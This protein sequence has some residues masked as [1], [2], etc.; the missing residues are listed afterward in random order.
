M[1]L[2]YKNTI[3]VGT[4]FL[5]ISLFWQVYDNIVS[6]ILDKVFLFNNADRGI[7]MALDNIV[8]LF[9]L[10]L[11]GTLSDKTHC[12]FGKRTPFIVVGTI[13]ASLTF[14]F[15]G[16]FAD[17]V[18]LVGFMIAL[19][20]VLFFMSI[21]RS[22]AVALMPD[23][24]I[25]P[26]RSKG[27][28]IINLMG[29]I[30]GLIALVVIPLSYK[31]NGA[32]LPLFAII[33]ALMILFLVVFLFTV[34]ENK[35]VELAEKDARKYGI[36]E[37]DEEEIVEKAT[38][39]KGKLKSMMFLLASVFLWFMA[40]NAVTSSFSVFA[41]KV[42]NIKGG[43]FTLPLMVA[44]V[45]A[46][47]MFIP[48]GII[49]SKIG[50]K[51]TILVGIVMMFIAFFFAFFIGSNVFGFI[52]IDLSGSVFSHPIFYL[53]VFF[54]ALCGVG[55][56]TINVNSYPMVVEMSKGSNVGK[57]TGY[58]YTASM[59]AQIITPYLSG[60]IMDIPQIGMKGM[61]AYSAVFI[62]LAFLTMLFVFHGDNKPTVPKNKLEA[63]EALEG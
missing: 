50:R 4:V 20:L 33:S 29:A 40:Y 59:L 37:D 11:F 25:K 44:Q 42:W 43:N 48:V 14:V 45:S 55:W 41:E 23:V 5:S 6:K 36:V 51:K 2:N 32:Y 17:K 28:A 46:I 12:R 38:L 18:N 60:L 1:K 39:N 34:R 21:F 9:M 13:L 49:A 10:P 27:N 54:F 56:A 16:F 62:A 58:Y 47:A 30:G 26:L 53:M 31:E 15:V 61:F 3:F 7:I 52:K 22:P 57:Y 24:T 19:G 63:F 8:A 35:L